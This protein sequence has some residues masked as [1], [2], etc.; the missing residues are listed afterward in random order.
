MNEKPDD[1]GK[2]GTDRPDEQSRTHSEEPS[3]TTVAVSQES[4]EAPQDPQSDESFEP[5][6]GQTPASVKSGA[7]TRIYAAFAGFAFVFALAA[8]A[9]VAYLFWQG[10][11]IGSD[12]ADMDASV[13][14]LSDNLD[15]ALSTLEAL[16]ERL[17]ALAESD[18]AYGD[19]LESLERQLENLLDRYE[20]I[21]ARLS[22]LEAAMASLQ[23]ISTGVRD[24]WWLAEAEYYMQLAN[25]QLQLAGN[26]RLAQ[27]ALEFADERIRQLGNPAL[28]DVRRALAGELR[29]LEAMEKADVEGI[30]MQLASLADSVES[31]PIEEY[32][33][34]AGR[35]AAPVDEEMGAF[36]RAVESVKSAFS[37]VVSVRRTDEEVR[38]LLS[39]DARY[40]L[41]A[42]PRLQMQTARLAML[43]GERAVF[44][45][46]LEDAASWLRRYFVTD[47]AAVRTALATIEQ[48]RDEYVTVDP[49]DI[50]RSLTL[51]RQHRALTAGERAAPAEAE[52]AE[53][54]PA[55]EEEPAGA[56]DDT[57]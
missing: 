36:D 52:P 50:S 26:P 46:S 14:T 56:D 41:R 35:E 47:S 1:A 12:Q 16:R 57:Q 11:D 20:N 30:T 43:R 55:V 8:L 33:T 4:E 13:A 3:S 10:R 29:A 45:Q 25:A 48:V 18:E 32:V 19:E 38:P 34:R 49:P 24:N 28:T 42:N 51:L 44:E 2:A 53:V 23:G 54:E 37:D 39:P 6:A 22:S 5:R 15:E 7:G 9:G 21:P 17:S 27:L 40:F 31:L